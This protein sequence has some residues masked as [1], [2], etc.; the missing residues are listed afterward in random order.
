MNE[1]NKNTANKIHRPV[2]VLQYGEGNF[3]RGFVDWMID[4]ANEK[5]DFN[6]NVQLVQ[7]LPQGLTELIKKQ[8]GLYHVLLQGIEEGQA[9]E[10]SRLITC[11]ADILNPYED[12]AAYL[13]LG[14]NPDLRFV[15]SNTTEAGITFD[16]T[17]SDYSKLPTTFPAKLTTLLYHRY[18]HFDGAT[19]KGLII[20]PC[21]L[22]D[23]NGNQL[24][25][26]ILNYI[27]LWQL[28][29][30][31]ADWVLSSNTFC[32]T[33]VDRIVPGFPK[34]T[35][36]QVQQKLGFTD[37]LVVTAEHFHLWVIEAPDHVAKE[38][39]L[40]KAGLQVKFVKDLT[41]YRT[42]KVRILNGGHTAMVPLAYLYGL[43]T[44]REA[45]EDSKLGTFIKAAI[46]E[47]II[48]TLDLPEDELNSFA[49]D[50][51]VRF[52]NPYIRHELS[53]IALNS[54]AKFKVRVLPSLLKYHEIKGT[55]P[56]NLILSFAALIRFYKGSQDGIA[57]P[58][59]DDDEV[60]AFFKEVWKN[61]SLETLVNTVLS[62]KK[63][64]GE[65]LTK[66]PNLAAEIKQSLITLEQQINASTNSA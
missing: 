12:Y 57:L 38:F 15:I 22:I 3:L 43:R 61:S 42:R 1:L 4:I 37:Q 60:L 6:G 14:T 54:I 52:A 10:S 30:A 46:Y 63:L 44:V 7:P 32:N 53:S 18:L 24:R 28:P 41:P 31:F 40:H 66:Y 16:H 27:S 62:E 23:Q 29:A 2:K 26:C 58:L 25:D 35:I 65:D 50:V 33:L 45:V 13:N 56:K 9:K 5:T 21:E 34:D 47:E 17:D 36:Q 51:L 49:D 19:E 59:K 64:W 48:P 20:I 11:I 55:W 39:P 8:D